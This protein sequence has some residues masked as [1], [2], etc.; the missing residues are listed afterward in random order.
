MGWVTMHTPQIKTTIWHIFLHT[1]KCVNSKKCTCN[2]VQDLL[3]YWSDYHYHYNGL[4]KP[5]T[6]SQLGYNIAKL[7]ISQGFVFKHENLVKAKWVCR[8][9]SAPKTHTQKLPLMASSTRR[10]QTLSSIYMSFSVLTADEWN[11]NRSK[12]Y[13][14]WQ[15][16]DQEKEAVLS[17][18]GVGFRV[19]ENIILNYFLHSL[20]LKILLRCWGVHLQKS[21]IRVIRLDVISTHAMPGLGKNDRIILQNL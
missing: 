21:G 15:L 9:V 5:H 6:S 8:S 12:L 2:F 10:D 11:K 18:C 4:I 19:K 20:R 13:Q 17:D 3:V 7:N 16:S 14:W 1:Y